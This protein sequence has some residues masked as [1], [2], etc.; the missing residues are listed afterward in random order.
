MTAQRFENL[1]VLSR[2]LECRLGCTE[3]C[4]TETGE[5]LFRVR[6]LDP[7]LQ[8]VLLTQMD[9]SLPLQMS[10]KGLQVLLPRQ[11]GQTLAEW[12]HFEKPDLRERRRMCQSLLEQLLTQPIPTELLALSARAENL[13]FGPDGLRL[14]LLP[15][16]N[17]WKQELGQEEAVRRVA[18]LMAQVLSEELR[19][20]VDQEFPEEL[21]LLIWRSQDG[22]YRSWEALQSDLARVPGELASKTRKV[23]SFRLRVKKVV[24]RWT[25][26]V[27]WIAVA[28]LVGAA[29]V[30]AGF[31]LRR[32][33]AEKAEAEP[34]WPGVS[35]IGQEP[36]AEEDDAA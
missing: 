13:R 20:R 28:L 7:G 4:R 25:P 27:A 35:Q 19:G 15:K 8:E 24:S 22:E 26:T 16:L 11:E 2:V 5:T 9:G 18:E 21:N 31:G 12:L 1:K 10:R 3:L 23:R 36:T 32:M 6:I 34:T 17:G 33:L 14:Q 30:S 29:I